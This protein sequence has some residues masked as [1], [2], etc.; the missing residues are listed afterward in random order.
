MK[1]KLFLENNTIKDISNF[2]YPIN[3]HFNQSSINISKD[4]KTI[5]Y[6]NEEYI[7]QKVKS[8]QIYYATLESSILN[9]DSFY[10]SGKVLDKKTKKQ[11]PWNIEIKNFSTD[12]MDKSKSKTQNEEFNFLLNNGMKYEIYVRS[13]GYNYN[14]F[15]FDEK[16]PHFQNIYLEPLAL[17]LKID[18]KNII[19]NIIIKDQFINWNNLH[20]L[21]TM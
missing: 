3:N 2:G 11:I 5:F 21:E 17:G 16:T 1:S 12:K 10:F 8:S 18:V 6:T 7:D 4:G 13:E 19:S 15:S 14:V 9:N 20:R